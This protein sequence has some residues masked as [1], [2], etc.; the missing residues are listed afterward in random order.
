ML[1][2]QTWEQFL[3]VTGLACCSISDGLIFGQMSGMLDAL[4][5]KNSE[6]PL[7]QSDLSWI[8]EYNFIMSTNN[9]G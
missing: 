9:T 6:I 2:P 8:G 3:V 5:S 4:H 1:Q 7:D